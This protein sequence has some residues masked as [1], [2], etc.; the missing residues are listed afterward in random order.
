MTDDPRKTGLDRKLIS[1]SEPHEV[2]S[3]TESLGCSETQLRDAV[4]E[5]GNSA[6]AVRAHLAEKLK[7]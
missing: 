1:L 6:E 2:R 4:K 5:V 7:K 3:W